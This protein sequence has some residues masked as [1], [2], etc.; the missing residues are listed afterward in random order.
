MK[1]QSADIVVKRLWSERQRAE[2]PDRNSPTLLSA[3][4]A[5]L[6]QRIG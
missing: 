6:W 4:G 2:L 1:A 3:G 5:K